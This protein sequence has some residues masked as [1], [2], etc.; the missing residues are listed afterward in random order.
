MSPRPS[1]VTLYNVKISFIDHARYI[2]MPPKSLPSSSKPRTCKVCGDH[3]TTSQVSVIEDSTVCTAC[4]QQLFELSLAN[5][6]S[7]PPHW[8][9]AVLNPKDFK[10]ILDPA[11]FKKYAVREKEWSCPPTERV[12]CHGKTSKGEVCGRFLGRRTEMRTRMDCVCCRKCWWLT[13]LKCLENFDLG[14]DAE[15]E[16]EDGPLEVEHVCSKEQKRLDP[17]EG[18]K[19]GQ[20]YQ[21]CP[22]EGCRRGA[23][24]AAGCK[25]PLPI[26]WLQ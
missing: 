15:G 11:F 4:V 12:Y 17:L 23:E 19:R 13:C 16:T 26:H 21:V 2:A 18:L 22:N 7:F 24:L 10:Q 20:D 8:G 6:N 1:K 3:L 25:S 9:K 14:E 5:E